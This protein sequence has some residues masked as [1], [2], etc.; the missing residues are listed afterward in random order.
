MIMTGGAADQV[1]LPVMF[2]R[3]MHITSE[4]CRKAAGGGQVGK[5]KT[6][7]ETRKSPGSAVTVKP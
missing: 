6:V 5:V 2:A 7:G 3:I 4:D 1:D